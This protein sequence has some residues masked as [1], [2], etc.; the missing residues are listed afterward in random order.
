MTLDELQKFSDQVCEHFE[1]EKIPIVINRR[2]K[3]TLGFYRRNRI[4]LNETRGKDLTTLR[5]ELAH[6]LRYDR[7]MKR[8]PG[9]FRMEKWPKMVLDSI[10]ENGGKHY[11]AKGE[12]SPV[13]IRIGTMH[14]KLFKECFNDIVFD[15]DKIE[16]INRR[17]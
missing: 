10:D 15:F 2:L 12:P 3:R 11:A 14:G 1:M 17:Q 13:Y 5:H 8:V 9:Y 6:H 7:Y 4:E 16:N